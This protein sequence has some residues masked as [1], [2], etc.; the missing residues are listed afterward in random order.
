MSAIRAGDASMS[1]GAGRRAAS[2]S[3]TITES[4]WPSGSCRSRENRSRSF[5][6]AARAGPCRVA[7]SSL[8]ISARVRI[9]A[10]T[11]PE[12][13]VPYPMAVASGRGAAGQ[14]NLTQRQ[15]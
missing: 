14:L 1:W 11:A 8:T 15:Q 9:A 7:R 6:T 2:D 12:M 4:V 3:T 13:K 5:S 10:V